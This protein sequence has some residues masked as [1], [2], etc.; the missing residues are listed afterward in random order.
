VG[1]RDDQTIPREL[2]ISGRDLLKRG[3]VVGGTL[4]WAAPVIHSL[5]PKADAQDTLE[6]SSGT[7]PCCIC[8]G[9]PR[10]TW[11]A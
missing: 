5:G 11:G 8:S 9:H 3:A 6:T 4:A 2:R 7:H 1:E 10:S